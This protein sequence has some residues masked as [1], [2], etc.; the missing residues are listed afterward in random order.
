[1][2]TPDAIETRFLA[3]AGV[4]DVSRRK[5]RALF[6]AIVDA[7]DD[8]LLTEPFLS[9]TTRDTARAKLH[10]LR[11]AMAKSRHLDDYAD[12]PI[13]SAAGWDANRIAIREHAF[14]VGLHQVGHALPLSHVFWPAEI[15]NASYDPYVNKVDVPAAEI[16]AGN[17]PIRVE[18]KDSDGRS[19]SANFTLKISP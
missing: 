6:N 18:V 8:E 16:P 7:F 14:D 11:L 13:S 5:A 10:A 1:M 12:V 19:G 15:V 9:L 17:H 3:L 2:F 4:D